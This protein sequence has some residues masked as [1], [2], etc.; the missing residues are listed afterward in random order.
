MQRFTVQALNALK[1]AK[2]TA[3]SCGHTYIGTEHLLAGLLKE[4]EGTAGK[5]L[6]EFQVEEARLMELIEK[7]IA[8]SSGTTIVKEPQYSPRTRRIIEDAAEDAEFMSTEKAGTE[9]L[10][11]AMLKE[12]DCVGTRLLH[13]MGVSI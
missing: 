5:V 4:P 3:Q 9:H 2:K 13:T 7:L 1:L 10:L 6:E 12:T 8:P 11:L